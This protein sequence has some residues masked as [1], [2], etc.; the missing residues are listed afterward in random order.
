MMQGR[1]LWK[2]IVLVHE[3]FVKEMYAEDEL[4][5]SDEQYLR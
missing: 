4:K 2:D 3:R 5:D 1:I